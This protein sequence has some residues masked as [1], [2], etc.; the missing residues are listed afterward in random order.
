MNITRQLCI[1]WWVLHDWTVWN[2]LKAVKYAPPTSPAPRNLFVCCDIEGCL[3]ATR[4][5]KEPTLGPIRIDRTENQTLY[6]KGAPTPFRC[7]SSSLCS[8]TG[9]VWKKLEDACSRWCKHTA[10][11]WSSK[12]QFWE[13]Y[14]NALRSTCNFPRVCIANT[15]YRSQD[16]EDLQKGLIM[17]LAEK[18]GVSIPWHFLMYLDVFWAIADHVIVAASTAWQQAQGCGQILAGGNHRIHY[19]VV[20]V[21]KKT[22][23]ICHETL[24]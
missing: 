3:Q 18:Q 19:W 8:R 17:E 5:I 14:V 22:S 9:I 7:R 2:L 1:L 16:V 12:M 10:L 13:A 24:P 11:N 6:T 21:W 4:G 23:L 15:I 20:S